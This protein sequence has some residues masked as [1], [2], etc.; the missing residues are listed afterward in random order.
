[1]KNAWSL[2]TFPT[3]MLRFTTLCFASSFACADAQDATPTATVDL[4]AVERRVFSQFGEDGVI[5]KIFEI[6]E[7]GPK[8][9]VEFGAHDGINNSNMRNLI[10]N[11]GWSSFQI[12]GHPARAEALAKNYASYPNV[13][14]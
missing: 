2:R 7:P 9:C 11:H 5:E 6:I 14:T 1:M 12:E 10:A 4:E 13:K 8:Y 3:L